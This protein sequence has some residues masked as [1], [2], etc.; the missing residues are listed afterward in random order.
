MVWAV[1]NFSL[2]FIKK[3]IPTAMQIEVSK[4]RQKFLSAY[5]TI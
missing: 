3:K 2:Y 4:N 5:K 1:V